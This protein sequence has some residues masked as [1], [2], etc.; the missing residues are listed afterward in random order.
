MK[1]LHVPSKEFLDNLPKG[2]GWFLANPDY[3]SKV[4]FKTKEFKKIK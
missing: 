3:I 4:N 1:Y 2:K